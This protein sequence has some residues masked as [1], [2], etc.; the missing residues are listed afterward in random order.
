MN[1][2]L[3]RHGQTI[4]NLNSQYQGWL[5]QPLTPLGIKQAKSLA[6][7]LE[8]TYQIDA[9]ISSPLKRAI[10][11]A[12]IITDQYNL[13]S[14]IINNNLKEINFG[15]WE[16]LTYDEIALNYPISK[17]LEN[18]ASIDIDEGEKWIDFNSRI[19]MAFKE[20]S[21]LDYKSVAI[22][23][24]AG[25]IRSFLST[26][27]KLKGLEMFKFNLENGSFSEVK[28]INGKFEVV[29]VNGEEPDFLKQP[30]K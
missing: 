22:V 3:I 4:A 29:L 13:D 8:N 11:T 23:S 9:V 5:D 10:Q 1:L 21:S 2:I 25:T 20:I 14:L 16:G 6:L 19:T 17:W 26:L 7:Y 15:K 12:Q 18:P 24:H 30:V 27:L 28:T